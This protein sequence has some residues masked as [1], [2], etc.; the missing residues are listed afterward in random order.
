VVLDLSKQ[1]GRGE[2]ACGACGSVLFAFN[3]LCKVVVNRFQEG[4]AEIEQGQGIQFCCAGCGVQLDIDKRRKEQFP[5][6][7][8]SGF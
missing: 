6:D 5:K 8:S 1:L 2:I 3:Q 7:D 4:K